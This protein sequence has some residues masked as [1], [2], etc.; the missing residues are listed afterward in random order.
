MKEQPVIGWKLSLVMGLITLSVLGGGLV[1]RKWFQ[2]SPPRPPARMRSLP[3]PTDDSPRVM[4]DANPPA[5][6]PH[7]DEPSP[8]RKGLSNK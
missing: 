1:V 8:P 2:A 3:R 6:M 4:D 5:R 7:V